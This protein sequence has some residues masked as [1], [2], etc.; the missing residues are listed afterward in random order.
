M[1]FTKVL[2]I[3]F[4]S[5]IFITNNVEGVD[6]VIK[7]SCQKKCRIWCVFDFCYQSCLK[8][9]CHEHPQISSKVNNCRVSCSTHRCFKFKKGIS[10]FLHDEVFEKSYLVF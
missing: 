6:E 10:I 9:Y 3:I 8:N 1:N 4:L 2:G 5:V 7:V